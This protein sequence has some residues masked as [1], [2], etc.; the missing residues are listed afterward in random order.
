MTD[1]E[2]LAR[3]ALRGRHTTAYHELDDA[4]VARIRENL[5][6]WYDVNKDSRAMP[7]R[8]PT[9]QVGGGSSRPSEGTRNLKVAVARVAGG[10]RWTSCRTASGK[11]SGRS[12]ATKVC[13]DLDLRL[14]HCRVS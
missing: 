3:L 6:A 5:L 4:D 12:A 9:P 7:W 13:L 10:R 1:I 8:L 2:D 14:G 11:R